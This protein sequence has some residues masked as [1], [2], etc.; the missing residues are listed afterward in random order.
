MDFPMISQ[1]RE[2]EDPLTAIIIAPPRS[3]L[4]MR[5]L[6]GGARYYVEKLNRR[7][8]D[9]ISGSDSLRIALICVRDAGF[10]AL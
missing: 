7:T 5:T 3:G 9:R 4:R 8:K 2:I 1:T 10:F 6:R